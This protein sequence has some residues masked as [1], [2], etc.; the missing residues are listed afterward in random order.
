MS[1]G[2]STGGLRTS[3]LRILA[4]IMAKAI[5]Q[6]SLTGKE[7]SKI[8]SILPDILS[9]EKNVPGNKTKKRSKL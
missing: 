2:L 7:L 6:E 3:S 1:Q 4:R 9:E 5:L 8:D